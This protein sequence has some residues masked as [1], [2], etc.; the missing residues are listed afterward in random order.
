MAK[1]SF[2]VRALWDEDAEVFYSESDIIGLHI[3]AKTIDEFE[4]V[5]M[6]V[7]PDLIVANHI[8]KPD[9]MNSSLSNLIP[10]IIWQRPETC[11]EIA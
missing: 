5:L 3:E 9:L 10:A 8:S 7:G 1:R 11:R 6:E 2:S 4:A